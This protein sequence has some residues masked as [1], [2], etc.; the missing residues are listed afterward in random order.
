[1]LS[2]T[3]NKTSNITLNKNIDIW[4]SATDALLE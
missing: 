1:M 3:K 2:K 4:L